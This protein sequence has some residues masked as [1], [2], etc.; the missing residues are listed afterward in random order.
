VR[1]EL[2]AGPDAGRHVELAAGTHLLG[3]A[4]HCELRID[5]PALE[6]HHLLID[7][8]EGGVV[9][10]TQLAGRAPVV[11]DGLCS[12][13]RATVGR[14]V[15]IGESR[16]E[17]VTE[18]AVEEV[19]AP[20]PP[21]VALVD[22]TDPVQALCDAARIRRAVYMRRS[23][24]A[25]SLGVGTVRLPIELVDGE[26]ANALPL[27]LHALLARAEWHDGLPVLLNADRHTVIGLVDD[28]P[29]QPRARAIARSITHQTANGVHLVIGGPGDPDLEACDGLLEVGARWRAR[30]TPDVDR[31][32]DFVRLHAAGRAGQSG[33]SSPSR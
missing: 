26:V 12:D 5:D 32:V 10:V 19:P 23:R 6:A 30:W 14:I 9:G 17:L 13:G 24:D 16:L 28:L 2:T 11:L 29:D 7:V 15:E 25:V 8:S 33:C 4:P 31:P 22:C 18:A 3:R 20:P 1:I 27:E 21:P